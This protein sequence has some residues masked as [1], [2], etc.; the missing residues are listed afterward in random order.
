[1]YRNKLTSAEKECLD[2]YS[3]VIVWG[4][5]LNSH[6][7]SYIHAMWVKVFKIGFEKETHW[8]HDNEFPADFDYTNCIFISEGYADNNIPI[9][10]SSVYFIH[11]AIYPEKYLMARLI[12]IRFNVNEI[13]DINNDF[14]RDDGSHN[15]IDI[16]PHAKYEK[17][18]SNKDI[19][20]SKRGHEIKQM[21]YECVYIYWGTPR[22]L[23]ATGFIILPPQ[24]LLLLYR[25]QEYFTIQFIRDLFWR[26]ISSIH[27]R[28]HQQAPL[29]GSWVLLLAD[30]MVNIFPAIFRVQQSGTI[31]SG[32]ELTTMEVMLLTV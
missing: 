2:R 9:V 31:W 16:T 24:P 11:N 3:K 1:M 14:K 5:P 21:N 32:W 4:F 27:L 22:E 12:E 15:L 19:H 6:T 23:R 18:T 29:Q 17:L 10:A 28:D 20:V 26:R 30:R 7:H 25:L 8:F 13:H